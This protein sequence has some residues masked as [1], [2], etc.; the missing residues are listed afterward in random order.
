M[1]FRSTVFRSGVPPVEGANAV[2][3]AAGASHGRDHF[4]GSLRC[5]HQVG[6][7]TTEPSP[8]DV[9]VEGRSGDRLFDFMSQRG[10]Q[11]PHHADAVH[12]CEIR[13]ELA[14]SFAR[15]FGALALGDIRYR[16]DED[17][18]LRNFAG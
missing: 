18:T 11:F 3:D 6:C 15:F 17:E 1:S 14:Q 13:L 7:V 16:P 9:S 4:R 8:A 12:M 10:G 5:F 2:D